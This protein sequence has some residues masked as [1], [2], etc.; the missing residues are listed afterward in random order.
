MYTAR[1]Q[2]QKITLKQAH[3]LDTE[4]IPDFAASHLWFAQ[5]R[6]TRNRM[7]TPGEGDMRLYVKGIYA[8]LRRY[9]DACD[10]DS[11]RTGGRK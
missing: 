2:Q 1:L 11:R 4:E 5:Y 7:A 3:Y 8:N 6:W 9:T 10:R